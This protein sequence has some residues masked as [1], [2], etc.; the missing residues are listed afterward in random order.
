MAY[1]RTCK[2]AAFVL[3]AVTAIE[4]RA[5]ANVITVDMTIS[6]MS[7]PQAPTTFTGSPDLIGTAT[8]Y[9]GNA[10]VLPV[11]ALPIMVLPATVLPI[12]VPPITVI[13]ATVFPITVIR[14]M[15]FPRTDWHKRV[16]RSP[17]TWR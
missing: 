17:L 16:R 14:V 15:D 2:T 12:T 9:V 10:T 5:L 1:G 8:F 3:I 6:Y 4:A 7:Y 13:L 11:T